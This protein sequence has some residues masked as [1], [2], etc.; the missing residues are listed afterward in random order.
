MKSTR[1]YDRY[2]LMARDPF[3]SK[4]KFFSYTVLLKFE[5]GG[6]KV[7]NLVICYVNLAIEIYTGF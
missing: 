6:M 3:R 7:C 2:N 5:H 4:E 1:P